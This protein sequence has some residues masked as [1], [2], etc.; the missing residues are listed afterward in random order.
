MRACLRGSGFT[1]AWS[2]KGSRVHHAPAPSLRTNTPR[3]EQYALDPLGGALSGGPTLIQ[4]TGKPDA[5]R[6]SG[7][8]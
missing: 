8:V 4:G 7:G 3:P 6:S 2:A 5:V 1:T